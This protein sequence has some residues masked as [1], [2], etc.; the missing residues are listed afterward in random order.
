MTLT[1]EMIKEVAAETEVD[2]PTVYRAA[3]H[4]PVTPSGRKSRTRARI[5]RALQ[6]RGIA[7]P[8]EITTRAQKQ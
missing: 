5:I 3:L 7:A 2:I 1:E 4:G 6:R 8:I